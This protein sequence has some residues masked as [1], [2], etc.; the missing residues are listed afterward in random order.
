MPEIGASMKRLDAHGKVTGTTEYPGDLV[1]PDM[2]YMKILFAG[3][4]HAR[5]VD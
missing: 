3:R 4:P 5:I 1:R 2:A